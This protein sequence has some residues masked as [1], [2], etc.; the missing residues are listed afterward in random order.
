MI[1]TPYKYCQDDGSGI[2]VWLKHVTLNGKRR[3]A[4]R[5]LLGKPDG[6]SQLGRPRCVWE[7]N[8]KIDLKELN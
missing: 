5:V 7:D 4:Y 6:K 2:K 3:S 8:I 1:C